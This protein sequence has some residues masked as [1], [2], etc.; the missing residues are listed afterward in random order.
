MAVGFGLRGPLVPARRWPARPLP[1]QAAVGVV[2]SA[3]G[4]AAGYLAAQDLSMFRVALIGA[5]MVVAP[6]LLLNV[7]L[8]AVMFPAF[9]WTRVS[10]VSI[11]EQGLPSLAVPFAVGLL[12]IALG[13]RILAGERIG[14]GSFRG[15]PPLLPCVR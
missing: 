8:A 7:D 3:L 14:P 13:R 2:A 9:L 10:D 1:V 15:L 12:G 5:A 4:L 6:V 11:A